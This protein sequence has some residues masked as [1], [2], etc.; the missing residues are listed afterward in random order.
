ME[1]TKGFAPDTPTPNYRSEYPK[2]ANSS[3]LEIKQ[4]QRFVK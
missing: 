1:P 4:R 2:G 3:R